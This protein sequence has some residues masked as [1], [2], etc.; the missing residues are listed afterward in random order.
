M[1]HIPTKLSNYL[2]FHRINLIQIIKA[3]KRYKLKIEIHVK[4]LRMHTHVSITLQGRAQC[5]QMLDL[6][7][8]EVVGLVRIQVAESMCFQTRIK[9]NMTYGVESS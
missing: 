9:L 5:I 1:K 6:H 8:G 2:M 4:P 7:S 3:L